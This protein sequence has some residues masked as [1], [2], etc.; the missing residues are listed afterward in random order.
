MDLL[1]FSLCN[2]DEK[3]VVRTDRLSIPTARQLNE[4]YQIQDHNLRWLPTKFVKKWQHTSQA[5]GYISEAQVHKIAE[6][7]SFEIHR[8]LFD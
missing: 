8:Q 3:K 6:E 5:K 2:I 7:L 1:D 4:S